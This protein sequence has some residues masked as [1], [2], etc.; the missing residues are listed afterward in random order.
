MA[1][2][3][4]TKAICA[5]N[6]G[7]PELIPLRGIVP[8]NAQEATIQQ[9]ADKNKPNAEQRAVI[10]RMDEYQAPCQAAVMDY[11]QR[12]APAG[13]PIYVQMN[14]GMKL[15]WA[16]LL[17]GEMTFGQFNSDRAQLASSSGARAEEAESSRIAQAQQLQAQRY[18]NYLQMQQNMNAFKPKTTNCYGYGNNVQCTQY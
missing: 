15:L 18:Q 6:D 1:E 5:M 3:Q 4:Q 10:A 12:R 13:A 16:K 11:L 7:R 8:S 9:L 14:Q 17:S 2:Q